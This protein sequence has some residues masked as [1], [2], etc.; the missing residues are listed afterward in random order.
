MDQEERLLALEARTIAHGALLKSLLPVL[1]AP[2]QEHEATIMAT[3]ESLSASTEGAML[4]DRRI[5]AALAERV[6]AELD[7]HVSGIRAALAAGR[8]ARARDAG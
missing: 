5:D 8:A 4:A 6:V 1:L 7:R 2:L 3:L